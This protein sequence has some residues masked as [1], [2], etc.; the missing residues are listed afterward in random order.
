MSQK[1][2]VILSDLLDGNA[3]LLNLKYQ[4]SGILFIMSLITDLGFFR[5]PVYLRAYI[6]VGSPVSQNVNITYSRILDS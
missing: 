5:S 1:H 3:E 2:E 4:G 6:A